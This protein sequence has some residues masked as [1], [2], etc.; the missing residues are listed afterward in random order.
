V[1][2]E[3]EG[4]A[5]AAAAAR[6]RSAAAAAA[7]RAAA[8]AA[9]KH[10]ERLW[11]GRPAGGGRR[12]AGRAGR[13][14][15]GG[16]ATRGR[17]RRRGTRGDSIHQVLHGALGV[18]ERRAH[19]A[20]HLLA[21]K[22]HLTDRADGLLQRGAGQQGAEALRVA[23]RGGGALGEGGGEMRRRALGWQRAKRV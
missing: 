7:S 2:Q 6:A 18:V 17:R 13:G 21:L 3:L 10:V 16:R 8:A 22:A 12:R 20:H 9:A 4:A 1:A 14:A 23:A 11:R 19:R 15:A 5:A